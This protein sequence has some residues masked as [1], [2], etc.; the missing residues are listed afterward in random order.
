M[1]QVSK[2]KTPIVQSKVLFFAKNKKDNLNKTKLDR[3]QILKKREQRLEEAGTTHKSQPI[4][5]L[6][7]PVVVPFL[8][9]MGE[10][11]IEE[12]ESTLFHNWK[13]FLRQGEGG[14]WALSS[15][16]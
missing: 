16:K 1:H 10:G 6:S 14:G 15:V 3:L 4:S 13:N 8:Q 2:N 11:K 7:P 5:P 12:E 9:Q